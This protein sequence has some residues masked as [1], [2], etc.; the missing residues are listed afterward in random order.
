[1]QEKILLC[2][3]LIKVTAQGTKVIVQATWATVFLNRRESD[4]Q[5][6][7]QETIHSQDGM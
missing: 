4:F 5:R 3:R 7:D 6:D 2:K 1:M